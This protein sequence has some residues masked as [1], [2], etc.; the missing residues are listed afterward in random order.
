MGG[1][2][3]EEVSPEAPDGTPEGTP[4]EFHYALEETGIDVEDLYLDTDDDDL[5]LFYASRADDHGESVEE[6]LDIYETF[7]TDLVE[8]GTEV[9][10][11][12]TEVSD[13]YDEQ[14]EGWGVNAEWAEDELAGDATTDD[15]L[16]AIETTKVYPDGEEPTPEVG[17]EPIEI[18]SD[19]EVVDLD[20][21]PTT[22]ETD[23]LP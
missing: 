3:R 8:P 10:H 17:D 2:S 6:I 14:A 5:I 19:D 7:R 12:Y 20:A 13:G 11:L 1:G 22:N 18:V 21:E 23:D 9:E 16:Y 15:V 4:A